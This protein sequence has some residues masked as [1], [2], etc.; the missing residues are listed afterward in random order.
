MPAGMRRMK[1]LTRWVLWSCGIA[2]LLAAAWLC[3]PKLGIFWAAPAKDPMALR[4]PVESV[5]FSDGSKVEI[6]GLAEDEWVD[7]SMSAPSGN[8]R[9]HVANSSTY[10]HGYDKDLLQIE[11]FNLNGKLAGVRLWIREGCLMMSLRLSDSGGLP[12]PAENLKRA[13]FEIQLS[14]GAGEWIRGYGPH[15]AD[16]DPEMRAVTIFE[17]W[18]RSGA[19]LVFKALLKGSPS[20]EFRLP[21]PAAGRKAETWAAESLPQERSDTYWNLELKEVREV[22]VPGQGRALYPVFEFENRLPQPPNE[23]TPID[24]GA[25]GIEGARGTRSSYPIACRGEDGDLQFVFPAP[26]N[27][28]L[29]KILYRVQYRETYP[30]PRTHVVVIAE[31]VVGADGESV[32]LDSRNMVLGLQSI[33]I[34]PL[35]GKKKKK[36]HSGFSIHFG[37][38]WRDAHEQSAAEA[39]IGPWSRD[40]QCVVFLND[41]KDSAGSGRFR[42]SSISDSFGT[43]RKNLEWNGTWTGDL[44]PGMKVEIGVMRR[45]PDDVLEFIIDRSSLS[46]IS[47]ATPESE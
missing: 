46:P 13:G 9:V 5:A 32:E 16:D 43:V 34:G 45:K 47:V 41:G 30:Y 23:W 15:G 11:R 10:S 6:F 2:I 27:E 14:D 40:W 35:P 31:G 4:T 8:L 44:E 20:V 38:G 37:G 19:E 25:H 24:G 36:G 12:V 3:G 7:G 39:R 26:P 28:D 21:N 33:E 1:N 29:F 42:N 18:P 17:G 22:L